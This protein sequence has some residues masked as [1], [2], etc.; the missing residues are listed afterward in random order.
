MKVT[1]L[2]QAQNTATKDVITSF[3]LEGFPYDVLAELNTHKLLVSSCESSRARPVYAVIKQ[4]EEDP[5]VPVFTMNQKGMSG[6]EIADKHL[7]A[8]AK[9]SYDYLRFEAVRQAKFMDSIGIHKQ[10][11]NGI[12]KPW[13]KVSII[14]TGTSWDNFFTLRTSPAAKGAIRDFAVEMK[15]LYDLSVPAPIALG[16]LF[17]PYPD[18]SPVEN[19]AK[20][21]SVS[22]ANHGKDRSSEDA[23]RLYDSLLAERHWSPFAA[24]ALAVEPGYAVSCGD[25]RQV[26]DHFKPTQTLQ[27]CNPTSNHIG[28]AQF[29]GFLQLRKMLG[30]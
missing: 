19:V 18:L 7:L 26:F 20:V 30:G 24:V 25:E 28:T 21:A 4:V 22:Y 3:L 15:R 16:E 14:I 27:K 5:Y 9:H 23:Q 12:L 8:N 10:D 17:L 29:S 1:I 11:I 13:M 6:A 2:N